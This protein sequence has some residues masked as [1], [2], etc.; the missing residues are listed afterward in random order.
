MKRLTTVLCSLTL[1]AGVAMTGT[2]ALAQTNSTSG[3]QTGGQQ[4][5]QQA[6]KGVQPGS[7]GQAMGHAAGTEDGKTGAQGS[8]MQ[9][10]ESAMSPQGASGGAET[11]KVKQ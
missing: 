6:G 8:L 4:A 11:G 2:S 10:R 7:A 9:K 3:Q 5:G 1:V